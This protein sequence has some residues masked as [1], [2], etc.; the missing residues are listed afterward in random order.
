MVEG[1]PISITPNSSSYTWK[2]LDKTD[3]KGKDYSYTVK[4]VG[5]NNGKVVI[6]RKNLY[7]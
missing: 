6:G 3:N 7:C 4:E 2:A 5:E 1:Q